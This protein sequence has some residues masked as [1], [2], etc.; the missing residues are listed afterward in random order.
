VIND[1][2]DVVIGREVLVTL[3]SSLKNLS[4]V[5]L[6]EPHTFYFPLCFIWNLW[7]LLIIGDPQ[8][9]SAETFQILQFKRA[10]PK[11][12]STYLNSS[13]TIEYSRWRILRPV[14]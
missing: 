14:P 12:T 8:R 5:L 2:D 6:G 1:V 11:P 7:V 9:L 4:D 3:E 10:N 13:Y